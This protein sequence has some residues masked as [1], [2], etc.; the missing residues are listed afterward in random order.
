MN[1]FIV[2][3][4]SISLLL[5]ILI[6]SLHLLHPTLYF[7]TWKKLPHSSSSLVADLIIRNGVIYTSDDSLPFVNSMAVANGRV[8]RIGNNSFVQGPENAEFSTY[9]SLGQSIVNQW[10]YDPKVSRFGLM[11]EVAGYGTQVLDL[12]GKVVVPGFI[13]SHVHFISGGLQSWMQMM[14]VGLRGV[15]EKEEVIRRIKEA[16][17]S[18]KPGSWILG[19]GWNNDLWGGDLPAACWID[20]VTPNNPVWLS[21]TDGHMGWANSVALTLAGITNL[22]DNPRGG[23]IMRT[24]GGEP[25]GLLIDSAMELVASQIPEVSIDDRRDALQKAS[26]LALTRGVTT[27]VDMGRYYPGM[28]ADLSWEDFTD[29]YLWTNAISKMKVRVCL[30]FPMVTWQR[31]ADLVNKMGHS[32][33]QWVY[34]GGVKAFADGSLGS[35]SALFYEPYQD[36]PDNYGLLVTEPDALLNMTSESDLSGLQVA[37]HAIG[38]RANDLIL[39][40]YSSVASKNGMRDRRFRIEHAQHLAPGTPSRFGKEGVVA[41]VQVSSYY[42]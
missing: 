20:D 14:Q 40:I 6:A 23:T 19:G 17:Q 7:L 1:L 38:D 9:S 31:L 12:Q 2:V 28:S 13:D 32:L 8:L 30:F 16:V 33:S 26:N 22:T 15:K 24:S 29:V 36:E 37:V 11:L 4:A 41:S 25:T 35:N 42:H 5:A 34:F 21:R 3:S 39:D 18:T 27:V 10:N